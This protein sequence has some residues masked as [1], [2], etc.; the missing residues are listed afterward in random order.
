MGTLGDDG[1]LGVHRLTSSLSN[2]DGG[3]VEGLGKY[4]EVG[5]TMEK[6][7]SEVPKG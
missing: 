2:Q 7:S 1:T 5:S 4:K 3:F 6:S